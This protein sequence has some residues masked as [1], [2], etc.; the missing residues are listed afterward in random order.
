MSIENRGIDEGLF[1]LLCKRWVAAPTHQT[2][3]MKLN[4]LG[5]GEVGVKVKP[6][7]GYTTG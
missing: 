4:Y 3:D 7:I 5:Q 2:M 6:N 1:S